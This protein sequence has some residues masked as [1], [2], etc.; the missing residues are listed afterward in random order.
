M[1]LTLRM[2]NDMI[3]VSELDANPERNKSETISIEQIREKASKV[4]ELISHSRE[5]DDLEIILRGES[6]SEWVNKGYKDR[7]YQIQKFL[8]NQ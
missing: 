5:L 7:F 2:P 8:R 1:Q 3:V 6:Y 4:R